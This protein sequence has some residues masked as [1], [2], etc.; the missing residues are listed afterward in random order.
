MKPI[1]THN[2]FFY[3]TTNKE[4]TV[5][6]TGVTND[7][8]TRLPQHKNDALTIKQHF[9]GK[10]NCYYLMFFERFLAAL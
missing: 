4:K 10:F 5:S 9:T 8:K 1:E 2:Y 6:Y 7:L 3:I